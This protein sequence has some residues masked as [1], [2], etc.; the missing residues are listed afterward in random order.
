[1]RLPDASYSYK[2]DDSKLVALQK[3]MPD[4]ASGSRYVERFVV[5]YVDTESAA[6]TSYL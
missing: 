3:D 6:G 1:M 5:Q 4:S 2:N